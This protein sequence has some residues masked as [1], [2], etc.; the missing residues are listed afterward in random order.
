VNSTYKVCNSPKNQPSTPPITIP[1]FTTTPIPTTTIQTTL[2]PDIL[3][4]FCLDLSGTSKPLVLLGLVLTRSSI[5][6]MLV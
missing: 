1:T 3:F 6:L 2:Q 4:G 5:N